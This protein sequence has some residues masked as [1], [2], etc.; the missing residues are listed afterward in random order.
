[1]NSS[2]FP[3]FATQTLTTCPG[4]AIGIPGI[5]IRDVISHISS[6]PWASDGADAASAPEKASVETARTVLRT[7]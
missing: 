3:F 4:I 7:N 2:S 6:L 5:S 1:M